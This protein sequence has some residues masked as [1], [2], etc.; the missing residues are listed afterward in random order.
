[1]MNIDSK[2]EVHKYSINVISRNKVKSNKNNWDV[3]MREML[4]RKEFRCSL[5]LEASQQ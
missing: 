2:A 1:M 3:L 4:E 5:E